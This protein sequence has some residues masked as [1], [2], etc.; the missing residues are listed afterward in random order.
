MRYYV[1]FVPNDPRL[2]GDYQGPMDK[3]E[4][5]QAA[6]TMYEQIET[7]IKP[8]GWVKIEDERGIQVKL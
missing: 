5:K 2:D 7:G 4:A 6:N 8:A 1:V 3:N